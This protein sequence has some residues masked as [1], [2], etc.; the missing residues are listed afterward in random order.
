[1]GHY[2]STYPGGRLLFWP[3]DLERAAFQKFVT[4]VWYNLDAPNSRV[5]AEICPNRAL[6]SMKEGKL[7]LAGALVKMK[8]S[9]KA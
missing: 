7:P 4:P 2:W 8:P 3:C 6:D 5:P 1:M 9:D